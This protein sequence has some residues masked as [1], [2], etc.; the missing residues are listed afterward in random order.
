MLQNAEGVTGLSSPARQ[1]FESNP[2]CR[3]QGLAVSFQEVFALQPVNKPTTQ[4]SRQSDRIPKEIAILLIGRDAQGVGFIEQTKPVVLCRHGVGIVSTH[5]LAVEQELVVVNR[6]S[7]KETEIRVVG[8]IGCEGN[9]Y[10]YGVAFLDLA[11]DFWGIEFPPASQLEISARPKPLQCSVCG[12]REVADLGALE[13]DIYAIHGGILRSCA[14]CSGSTLWKVSA[15]EVPDDSP[16]PEALNVSPE[17]APSPQSPPSPTPFRNRR[18]HVRIKVSFTASVRNHSSD[19]D[20]VL[21]E[22]VSR[23]GLCFKS[24]RRYYE[25]ASIEVA[26]PYSPGLPRIPVPALI[27]YV[28]ELPLEK[29]FRYGVRYLQLMKDP[30]S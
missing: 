28:Q 3:A 11:V 21:C 19:D 5:K 27:V 10:T 20:I 12:L 26:A 30:R 1:R 4:E 13:S 6:E 17:S 24:S 8:Q 9:S 14:R 7:N 2:L 16:V 18:Q 23:G 15:G 29:M 22:N 25:T